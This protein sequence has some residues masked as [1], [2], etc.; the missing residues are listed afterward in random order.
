MKFRTI[1]VTTFDGAPVNAVLLCG[2]SAIG[3]DKKFMVYSLNEKLDGGLVRIYL[4]S[5]CDDQND[6]LMACVSPIDF[7]TAAQILKNIINDALSPAS[8]MSNGTYKILDLLDARILPG[9]VH[10]HRSLKVNET[11]VQKLLSF[12]PSFEDSA[13][14]NSPSSTTDIH[15]ELECTDYYSKLTPLSRYEHNI[16]QPPL[17]AISK[18]TTDVS[19]SSEIASPAHT[20]ALIKSEKNDPMTQLTVSR[21]EKNLQSLLVSL[22]SHKDALKSKHEQFYSARLELERR[23]RDLTSREILLSQREEELSKSSASLAIAEAQ[24]S[25]LILMIDDASSP[26]DISRSSD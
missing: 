8:G 19:E 15:I 17:S 6:V 20:P 14:A 25:E 18:D 1:T 5:L 7:K 26:L 16:R 12:H 24:L 23:D 4:A 2:F 22:S 3:V 13:Q 9:E 11:W 21:I 10:T